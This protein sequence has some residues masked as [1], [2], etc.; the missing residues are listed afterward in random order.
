MAQTP[1]I[2]QGETLVYQQ[3]KQPAQ[4]VVGTSSWY[5]WLETAST[6]TFR[7][8]HGTFTARKERAG[9]KRGRS[10]WRAYRKCNGKLHRAYLGKSEELT[11][12]RLKVV[13]ALLEGAGAGNN[14]L[15]VPARATG[16]SVP[17]VA[18]SRASG[19]LRLQ[20]QASLS[21]GAKTGRPSSA[22]DRV[23]IR[24]S[25]DLLMPLTS[26]IGREQQVQ[27]ICAM[28]QRPEV[29]L[30]TLTGTG[31]VGKTRLGL[32]V[33]HALLGVFADGV[34]F[35]PLAP[36][37]DPERVIAT[38][39][40][41]LGLWEVGDRPLIEQLQAY[42]Q[43]RHLLLLLDNFEQVAAAA[44]AL[45]DLLVFCPELHLLVTSRAVLHISG[46]YEFPV[47]PLAVPDLTQ[48]LEH[49]VLAQVAAVSLFVQRAQATQPSFT[50]TR[51]NAHTIAEICVRL[52]GLPLTIELA[53]ARIKLLPPQALLKRLEHR[54]SVLTGGARNLPLRQQTLRNTIQWSYDLLS[55]EERRLFRWLSVFVG[56]CTL[57]AAAAV[58]NA[59]TDQVTELFEEV[60]SLVDKSLIQQ[61][62]Q[63]EE[64]P[65]LLMLETIREYGL[66]CLR[67]RGELEA[68]QRA[69]AA[70]YLWLAEEAEPHLARA[71]QVLW[72][73]R[74]EREM[75]N[76]RAVLRW[77]QACGNEEA[78]LALRLGSALEHFWIK[79]GNMSEG[80][81]ELSRALVQ[82]LAVKAPLR[83]KA[84]FAAARLAWFQGDYGGVEQLSEEVSAL[85]GE[86]AEQQSIALALAVRGVAFMGRRD[87]ERARSLLEEALAKLRGGRDSWHIAFLLIAL[88]RLALYQG[89][90]SNAAYLLEESLALFRAVGDTTA[91]AYVL[92]YLARAMLGQGDLVRARALLEES[93]PLY[94]EAGHK[95][96]MAYALG[97]LGQIVFQQGEVGM[98][99][100]LFNESIQLHRAMGDRQGESRSL[101]HWAH[102]GV[103][104]QD[105]A[106]ARS[107]YE[108]SLTLSQ[109]LGHKGLIAA[110]LKGLAVVATAQGL[111]IA[112]VRLWGA[113]ETVDQDSAVSLPL[114]LRSSVGQAQARARGYLGEQA[115]IQA[116]AEGRRMSPE[117]ALAALSTAKANPPVETK[118]PQVLPAKQTPASPGGL[119][120][121]EV[122]VLRLVAKGLT[123][124]QVAEQLII[125]PRTVNWHLTSIYNKLGINSRVAAARFAVEHQLV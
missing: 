90:D 117:Q 109:A 49:E 30:L 99:D 72:F 60:A 125:S 9:N 100:A 45:A 38:I 81:S 118:Q 74:L 89:E 16:A 119:T 111:P 80:R 88:G 5:S 112:S 95:L 104:Q 37:S 6:F 114:V 78:Q 121:R 8:E 113:A 50:L 120:A 33:A 2:I 102:L 103:D 13:A 36:V 62:E 67:E 108:E 27:T 19:R 107:R 92:F 77:A 46:E 70:Y 24:P 79:R 14:P 25:S 116:W 41:A 42:L 64:E 35:V 47:A 75:E 51:S 23:S 69:H 85:S 76:I 82:S 57:K 52:D 86:L 84:L 20:M 4:L 28:L 123:D 26:L 53:A 29:R 40:Q 65:R 87:Y 124:A 66:E 91:T 61:T 106:A 93:L 43:D 31:G 97:F 110:G 73:E 98:A 34:C 21:Q 101:L 22:T 32:A 96:G 11:L 58:Y 55:A 44:P 12:E 3:D 105:Y 63:E 115:F 71:E 56:G 94:R 1:S 7:S 15:A 122:E 48:V 59:G 10:Y 54:L 17:P 39:V 83:A 18:S 68:A